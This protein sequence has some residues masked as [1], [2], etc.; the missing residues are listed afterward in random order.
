MHH[1]RHPDLTRPLHTATANST[2]HLPHLYALGGPLLFGALGLALL[3]QALQALLE[4]RCAA[5][6]ARRQRRPLVDPPLIACRY[7]RA[8]RAVRART[9]LR[10]GGWRGPG[11]SRRVAVRGLR[12]RDGRD[13]RGGSLPPKADG[14]R[15]GHPERQAEAEAKGRAAALLR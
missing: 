15:L 5:G 14:H 11:G 3:L 9:P 7:R 6:L 8:R 1:A 4:Q 13:R 10:S 2:H 12:G